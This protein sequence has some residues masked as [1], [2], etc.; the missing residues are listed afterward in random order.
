[1]MLLFYWDTTWQKNRCIRNP[2][3]LFILLGSFRQLATVYYQVNRPPVMML[4][5]IF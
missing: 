5:T 3:E 4:E 1:M 2:I